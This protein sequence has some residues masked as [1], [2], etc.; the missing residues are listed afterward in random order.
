MEVLQALDITDLLQKLWPSWKTTD[1]ELELYRVK[2]KGFDFENVKQGIHEH[3]TSKQ[4]G[5]NS[6]KLWHI[7]EILKGKGKSEGMKNKPIVN[8][9]IEC[10][11]HKTMPWRVGERIKFWAADRRFLYHGEKQERAAVISGKKAHGVYGGE[12]IP[13]LINFDIEP[14]FP[15][16]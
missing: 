9:E 14:D 15:D 8:Y 7:L 4:G 16:F 2:L 12:W 5:V 3:K 11:E 10:I 1:T 13:R 6:P